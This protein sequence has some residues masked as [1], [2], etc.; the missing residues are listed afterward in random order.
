MDDAS[1][2]PERQLSQQD[3]EQRSLIVH[4]QNAIRETLLLLHQSWFFQGDVHHVQKQED[5]EGRLLCQGDY[6]ELTY[7]VDAYKHAEEVRKEILSRALVV[8]NRS[9]ADMQRSLA[10]AQAITRLEELQ[11]TRTAFKSSLL[12]SDAA[13]QA[14]ALLQIMNE[15]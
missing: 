5:L 6:A 2:T 8:A 13:T 11:T 15:K 1:D 12:T 4:C 7:A 9:V 10:R 3:R 14:S